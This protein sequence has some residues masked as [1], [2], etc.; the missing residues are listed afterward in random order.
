M[1]ASYAQ[2]AR[3][4]EPEDGWQSESSAFLGGVGEFKVGGVRLGI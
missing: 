3:Q 1:Q 2:V 4:D